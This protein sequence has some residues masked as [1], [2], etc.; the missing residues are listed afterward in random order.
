MFLGWG[1]WGL[2]VTR[3]WANHLEGQLLNKGGL[4]SPQSTKHIQQI[5]A[6]I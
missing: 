1:W 4:F 6:T 2:P 3:V 5:T